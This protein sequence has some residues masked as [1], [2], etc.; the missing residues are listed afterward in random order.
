[1]DMMFARRSDGSGLIHL[2]EARIMYQ[3]A[4]R[5]GNAHIEKCRPHLTDLSSEAM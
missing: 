5:V 4:D 1:M 2:T 3:D